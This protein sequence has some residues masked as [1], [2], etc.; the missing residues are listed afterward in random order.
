MTANDEQLQILR[1]RLYRKYVLK[2]LSRRKQVSDAATHFI[3][4]PRL[5][6]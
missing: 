6:T 4:T 3:Q 1:Q 5:R 2:V